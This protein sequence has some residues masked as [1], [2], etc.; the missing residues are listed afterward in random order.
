MVVNL[1]QITP[2]DIWAEWG[3]SHVGM[4]FQGHWWWIVTLVDDIITG[5]SKTE[6]RALH[7]DPIHLQVLS[8]AWAQRTPLHPAALAGHPGY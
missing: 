3:L 5:S 2:P 4:V 1:L 7:V 8:R 6:V